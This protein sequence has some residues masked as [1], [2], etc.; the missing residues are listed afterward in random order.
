MTGNRNLTATRVMRKDGHMT[1]VHKKDGVA[2]PSLG[3][4][5]GLA[6]TLPSSPVRKSNDGKPF[7]ARWEASG[8]SYYAGKNA[9]PM[10]EKSLLVRMGVPLPASGT[11]QSTKMDY[12]QAY[13]Y[14]SAGISLPEAGYLHSLNPSADSWTQNPKYQNA[15]PGT[16]SYVQ[17]GSRSRRVEI[18]EAVQALREH[19]VEPRT[20]QK[21]LMNGFSDSHLGGVLSIDQ[22]VE[23]FSRFKHQA[24][25]DEKKETNAAATLDALLDGRLPYEMFERK[26]RKTTLTAALDAIYP[27]KRSGSFG[28]ELDDEDREKFHRSPELIL[29][30][31]EE[32]EKETRSGVTFSGLYKANQLFGPEACREYSPRLLTMRRGD[33]SFLGIEGARHASEFREYAK[34]KFGGGGYNSPVLVSVHNPDAIS[35]HDRDGYNFRPDTQVS[36]VDIAEMREMGAD[37]EQILDLIY[38]QRLNGPQA[39]AILTGD[40]VPALGKGW[41]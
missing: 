3:R 6:P 18:T 38:K 24:S 8:I 5:S 39:K 22:K 11:S 2:S 20:A 14:M 26:F 36:Y 35:V 15:L 31:A 1:T 19:G 13:E 34:N 41:L 23:L 12:G 27:S 21:M 33:G 28:S 25:V 10:G 29:E 7:T 4:L 32:Y 40:T 30:T 17:Y 16:L 9:L 37:N